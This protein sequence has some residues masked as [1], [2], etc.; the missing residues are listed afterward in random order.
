MA[1]KTQTE[2]LEGILL[3]LDQTLGETKKKN[4]A[5][6]ESNAPKGAGV[7]NA[8]DVPVKVV[9][10]ALT[11]LSSAVPKLAKIS[12]ETYTNIADGITQIAGAISSIKMDKNALASVNNMLTAFTSIH[13][14]ITGLGDNLLKT[15]IKFN[16]IRGK[17]IGKAMGRFYGGVL[18]GLGESF[19]KNLIAFYAFVPAGTVQ[20]AKKVANLKL[21]LSGIL[22]ISGKDYTKLW[23]IGRFFGKRTSKN[24]GEFFKELIDKLAGGRNGVEKAK[25]ASKV[26]ISVAALVGTLSLCLIALVILWKSNDIKDI[27]G[28]IGL[29]TL[30]VAFALGII[31]I[32]GSNKFKKSAVEGLSGVK[33]ILLLIGG[34]TLTLL[35]VVA[36]GKNDIGVI[37][38]G[39]L[40]FVVIVGT[41]IGLMTIL[42]S[43]KFKQQKVESLMG[44]AAVLLLI[45]GLTI[46][47]NMAT[48]FADTWKETLIGLGI[49]VAFTIAAIGLLFL[50]SMVAKSKPRMINALLGTAAVIL[51]ITG[52]STA[53]L[54]YGEFL[55]KIKGIDKADVWRGYGLTM[56]MVGGVIAVA[57]LI[58]GILNFLIPAGIFWAGVGGLSA[59]G[60]V[61]LLLS[62]AMLLFVTFL[63]KVKNLKQAD[64]NDAVNKILGT[65]FGKSSGDE[66]PEDN[67]SLMGALGA[68]IKG[69]A[70]FGVKAA[71]EAGIVARSIKPVIEA[72]SDFVDVVQKMATLQ[73]ADQWDP[74]TG[75]PTHYLQ[76]SP[77]KFKEAAKNLTASFSTFL[78]DLS[79]GLKGFDISSMDIIKLL[80]PRQSGLSKL[81]AGEKPGIGLVIKTLSDFVDVIHKMASMSVPDQWDKDGKPI[82]YKKLEYTD[83]KSAAVNLSEAFSAFI[84]ELGVGLE[85]VS[86]KSAMVLKYL[87]GDISAVLQG[88]GSAFG[89]IIQ[90]AAGKLQVGD[91][92]VDITLPKLKQAAKDT[93]SVISTIITD[94]TALKDNGIDFDDFEDAFAC[95]DKVI[96]MIGKIATSDAAKEDFPKKIKEML[97]PGIYGIFNFL[98]ST[99][100]IDKADSNANSFEDAMEDFVDG[101]KELERIQMT[102]FNK[103]FVDHSKN[104]VK[105]LYKIFNFLQSTKYLATAKSNSEVFKDVMKNTRDGINY[106]KPFLHATPKQIIDLADAMKK[107]DA[108][109]IVKEEQRTKAIQSVASN[110]KDMAAGVNQLNSAMKESMRLTR[111]YSAMKALTSGN[112]ISKG[113]NAAVEGAEKMGNIVKDALTQNKHEEQKKIE[114][115][116]KKQDREELAAVIGNAVSAALTAWS[117]SHKEL[118]VQFSD[119]PEKIFGEI[120][121]G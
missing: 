69:M 93:V 32:L 48:K 28:G 59:I 107:L 101:V 40:L 108:E 55:K 23:L 67:I 119:S 106:I 89:P 25:A 34:L 16:R 66:L 53:M 50:L 10:D 117:E 77:E 75:K 79:K 97:M 92:A 104:L 14:I 44:V 91:Q 63:E 111:L 78:T 116:Q 95:V 68:I 112:I 87:G 64:I 70:S 110:F 12:K 65:S 90:I 3:I 47:A 1:K 36:I 85:N 27:L 88:I 24:I 56:A 114:E 82:S 58:G 102:S 18:S 73:I 98:Q 13:N 84:T 8:K 52:I 81:L 6:G 37:A 22:S 19:V 7:V 109:L 45:L 17:L 96:E 2:L 99:A 83:F 57:M 5:V 54:I 118:T 103:E 31:Y 105:G 20:V 29:L 121:N 35:V 71:R 43:K 86:L 94:L 11:V 72:I 42:S 62:S 21:M 100:Y 76:L 38:K 60:G 26:A 61:I 15:L 113:V 41:A 51:L 49:I 4:K 30:V 46:A 120:R 115:E 80:F 39:L 74:K 9:G 33:M